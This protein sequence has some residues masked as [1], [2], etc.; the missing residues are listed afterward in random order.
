MKLFGTDG[1]RFILN[2][3]KSIDFIK[4]LGLAIASLKKKKIVICSDTREQNEVI[5]KVLSE[6]L[7]SY[8]VDIYN[9]GLSSTP[10]L[11]YYSLKH[12]MFGII[13]T[14]SHNKAIYSGIKFIDKGKKLSK[15][16]EKILE[17]RIYNVSLLKK[18][19]GKIYDIKNEEYLLFLNTFY[20]F[21]PLKIAFD[22]ANGATYKIA[23][24]IFKDNKNVFLYE[25]KPDGKNINLNVGSTNPDNI[26]KIV[27]DKHYDLGFSLDGDGDRLIAC[28]KNGRLINGDLL[29]YIFSLYLLSINALKNNSIALTKMSNIGIETKLK[30]KGI[31][32]YSTSIGDKYIYHALNKY[33]LSLGGESSGHIILKNYLPFGDG[34]FNSLYLIK[35]L[36]E[37]KHNISD[38]L[39]DVNLFYEEL[40]NIKTIYKDKI[41]TSKELKMYLKNAKLKYKNIKILIRKSGTE[42]VLR[43]LIMTPTKKLL[44]EIKNNILALIKDIENE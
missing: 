41:L 30:Q 20:V 5:F 3:D 4:Q 28:D 32:I 34:L 26:A 40:I 15:R 29:I 25:D 16:T 19:I 9:L 31:K 2:Q 23:K 43:I 7:L 24:E 38:M 22:L 12:N 27:M 6:T 36:T 33:D 35:L 11:M 21:S 14:A 1:I 17:K 8:G 13:L 39:K 44:T 18:K 10:S 42:D 37:T